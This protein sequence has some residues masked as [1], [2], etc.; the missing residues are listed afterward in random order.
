MTDKDAGVQGAE[1]SCP[2]APNNK[3]SER[4]GVKTSP[5]FAFITSPDGS[6]N[7]YITKDWNSLKESERGTGVS[8]DL[9][10]AP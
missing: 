7:N 9:T 8:R 1:G 3:A 4:A 10:V 5:S 2:L 6:V